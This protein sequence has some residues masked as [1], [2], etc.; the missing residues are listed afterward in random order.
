VLE[1]FL[2]FIKIQSL[3]AE[4]IAS[5]ILE[6]TEKYGL[7]MSKLV[8]LGFDGCSTMSGK[9]NGVQAIIKKSILRLVF[10]TVLHI[11]LI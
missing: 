7:D 10:F 8:G 1:E 4:G 3:N 9:D 11:S 5:S 6:A 2:G